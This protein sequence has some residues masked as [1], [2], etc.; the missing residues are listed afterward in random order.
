[1]AHNA[2]EEEE[3]VQA[4]LYKS[5]NNSIG[6]A[7]YRYEKFIKDQY[8]PNTNLIPGRTFTGITNLDQLYN[9]REL[10]LNAG[11]AIEILFFPC[12]SSNVSSTYSVILNERIPWNELPNLRYLSITAPLLYKSPSGFES[13]EIYLPEPGEEFRGLDHLELVLTCDM[14]SNKDIMSFLDDYGYTLVEQI[15]RKLFKGKRQKKPLILFVPG[16]NIERS[17]WGY[18]YLKEPTLAIQQHIDNWYA[19]SGMIE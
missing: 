18:K 1:M 9:A 14:C 15:G 6:E 13:Y 3:S 12:I 16:H 11:T 7:S 17:S 10:I 8:A 5:I 19:A 2:A 4:R